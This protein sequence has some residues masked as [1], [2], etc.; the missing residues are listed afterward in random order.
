MENDG[1]RNRAAWVLTGGRSSR[2]RAK[3]ESGVRKITDTLRRLEADGFAVR[4]LA[5]SI[6]E[7]FARLNTP[8]EVQKYLNG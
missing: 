7:P 5:V 3:L 2:V 8:E 6:A 4:Y 1:F